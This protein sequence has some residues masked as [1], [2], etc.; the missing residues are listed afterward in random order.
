MSKKKVFCVTYG[1]GHANIIKEI[2]NS[3]DRTEYEV[4]IL[5]LTLADVFFNKLEIEHKTISE[6]LMLFGEQAVNAG[7]D[8]LKKEDY[9]E[10]IKEKDTEVY[11]GI[12]FLELAEDYGRDNA[13][14]KYK[15][16]GRKCF[17]PIKKMK[18]IIEY[19]DPD[20]VVVTNSP[21]M[22]RAAAIA[23]N[24]LGI[25]VVR[26]NDLPY[27]S[28]KMEY[29]AK[30]CVMNDWAKTDIISKNLA[31]EEDIFVTGQPVFEKDLEIDYIL[32]DKYKKAIRQRDK[33]VILYLGQPFSPESEIAIKALY[34]IASE[35]KD[36]LMIFRPHP[37]DF[38][39]YTEYSDLNNFIISKQGELKYL[40]KS[41]D[42][43]VTHYSTGGLQA[44]LL[45]RPLV[46]LDINNN[47]PIDYA[48]LGIA[49]NVYDINEL[50]D[51]ISMC[52]DQE[53]DL[54]MKLQNGRKN[55][56]N[57]E[58]AAKSICEVIISAI[59]EGDC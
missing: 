3:L 37:N 20:V 22:E 50:K 19:E 40:I 26:V 14:Q 55:F 10:L 35:M 8:I 11:H 58:N 6:Y 18:K 15:K 5:A 28:E 41:S 43:V 39:D 4:V 54:Y 27:M 24:E 9:N 29:R 46:C 34:G 2:Y 16:D 52:L 57:K 38:E 49:Y 59:K 17:L 32:F 44:A 33:N 1:A 51:A 7:K 53:S 30:L 56:R 36:T 31:N 13:L 25:P 45:E 12:S 21:R 47:N 48:A 23:A 42:L